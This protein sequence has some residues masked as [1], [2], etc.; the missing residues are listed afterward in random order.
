MAVR[1]G[2]CDEG[3]PIPPSRWEEGENLLEQSPDIPV[4]CLV[5]GLQAGKGPELP[6]GLCLLCP[7]PC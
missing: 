1:S 2:P 3:S 5:A 7:G 6:A 4:P